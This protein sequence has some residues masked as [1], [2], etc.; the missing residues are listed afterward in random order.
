MD[1]QQRVS[2]FRMCCW[3]PL[4]SSDFVFGRGPEVLNEISG[5]FTIFHLP[6]V[7]SVMVLRPL[8]LWWFVH[9][10]LPFTEVNPCEISFF[11]LPQH[12]KLWRPIR[13]RYIP[14]LGAVLCSAQPW[15]AVWVWSWFSLVLPCAFACWDACPTP[16]NSSFS[17][18]PWPRCG[19]C[20]E[21]WSIFQGFSHG[22]PIPHW[23][24]HGKPAL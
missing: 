11:S 10:A 16:R 15:H 23:G 3:T 19:H 17:D 24:S 7:R 12:Q 8:M 9:G 18:N 6:M 20:S 5:L 21:I 13:W 2:D 4:E 14:S 1:P 22:F